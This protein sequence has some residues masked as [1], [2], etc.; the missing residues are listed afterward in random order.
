M[1][2][3]L[4]LGAGAHLLGARPNGKS[5]KLR[6]EDPMYTEMPPASHQAIQ[7]P[8]PE[9]R[10]QWSL[11]K[12][13]VCSTVFGCITGWPGIYSS[14]YRTK[15]REQYNLEGSPAKDFCIHCFCEPCSLTQQYRELQHRGFDVPL[16]WQE[17][18]KRQ[19]Q[20]PPVVEVGMKR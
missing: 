16:G 15:M 3:E 19:S 10:V 6:P 8:Q 5:L 17:N 13:I 2:A 11:A 20:A 7:H 4:K 12:R 1:V 14:L 9:N 18:M